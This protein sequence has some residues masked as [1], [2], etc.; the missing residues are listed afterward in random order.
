VVWVLSKFQEGP[1]SSGLSAFR[2][3]TIT[4]GFQGPGAPPSPRCEARLFATISYGP[5]V[6]PTSPRLF[7]LPRSNPLRPPA[8]IPALT[9]T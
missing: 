5:G 1:G 2:F 7:A 3:A 8:E 6:W 4:H 9:V